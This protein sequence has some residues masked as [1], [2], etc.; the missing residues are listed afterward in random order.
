M[1]TNE[2]DVTLLEADLSDGLINILNKS[3]FDNF[4][5]LSEH[6]GFKSRGTLTKAHGAGNMTIKTIERLGRGLGY[7]GCALTV[8]IKTLKALKGGK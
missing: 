4:Y 5:Q 6:C 1:S 2:F 3:K 8:S 7:K